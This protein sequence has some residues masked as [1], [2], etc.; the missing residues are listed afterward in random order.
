MLSINENKK[1]SNKTHIPKIHT[2]PAKLATV[3]IAS[4]DGLLFPFSLP[5]HFVRDICSR[6]LLY[7]FAR[8]GRAS[9]TLARVYRK[10]SIDT[11]ALVVSPNGMCGIK[12]VTKPFPNRR[13]SEMWANLALN[14]RS[15]RQ[16]MFN[17]NLA[18][19]TAFRLSSYLLSAPTH[20]FIIRPMKSSISIAK[21]TVS[22]TVI[23]EFQQNCYQSNL[24]LGRYSETQP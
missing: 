17:S 15:D 10:R 13:K 1:F 11:L 4:Y 8:R 20:A 18:Y 9:T 5:L 24:E 14:H 19:S 16:C 21:L 7:N 22:C 3:A 23:L 6:L 12:V 2:L